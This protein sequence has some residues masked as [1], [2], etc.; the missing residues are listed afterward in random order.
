M[1]LPKAFGKR[2]HEGNMLIWEENGVYRRLLVKTS[3]A[4][5]SYKPGRAKTPL[6]GDF[7][8]ISIVFAKYLPDLQIE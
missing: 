7:V 3:A 1:T 2:Q 8:S 4:S 5:F 6:F